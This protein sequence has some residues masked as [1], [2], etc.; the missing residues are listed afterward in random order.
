[1]T[2]QYLNSPKLL[3]TQLY[4]GLY[5]HLKFPKS[6]LPL[7]VPLVNVYTQSYTW[8]A[9][10]F[11]QECHDLLGF[12]FSISRAKFVFLCPELRNMTNMNKT[13][14]NFH[15]RERDI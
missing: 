2:T 14:L 12:S 3:Y 15:F 13:E 8:H 5:A 9:C 6:P 11:Y 7:C 1:M 4:M 10:F